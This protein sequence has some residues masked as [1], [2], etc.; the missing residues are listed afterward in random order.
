MRLGDRIDH[1]AYGSGMVLEAEDGIVR[2]LWDDPELGKWPG[3]APRETFWTDIS[4]VS[5]VKKMVYYALVHD[6][7]HGQ[8]VS[9]YS[10]YDGAQKAGVN[11]M[12]DIADEWGENVSDLSDESLWNSWTEIAGDTEFFSINELTLEG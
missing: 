11:F 6:H 12:R 7:K 2:V 4:D 9:L 3:E 1:H 10:T 5:L 8:D